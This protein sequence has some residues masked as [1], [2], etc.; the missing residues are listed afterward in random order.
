MFSCFNCHP[1]CNQLSFA[2]IVMPRTPDVILCLVAVE[3][4]SNGNSKVL[5][6]NMTLA[7]EFNNKNTKFGLFKFENT[8][9]SVLYEL[10][11]GGWCLGEAKLSDGGLKQRN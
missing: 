10:G 4:P 2:L 11:H 6:S 5:P 9:A 7:A 8:R 3:N 1:E